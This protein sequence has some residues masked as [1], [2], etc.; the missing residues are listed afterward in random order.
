MALR[1]YHVNPFL[2]R[3]SARVTERA[4][5]EARPAV[6]RYQTAFSPT[7]GGKPFDRGALN[8]I[9]VVNVFERDDGEILHALA[10]P[11][12]FGVGDSVDGEIDWP[13]RFDHMQQHTGQHVLSAAFA[14]VAG[15]DT[16]SIHIGDEECTI[17]LPTPRLDPAL[18]ERVEDAANQTI[19]DDLPVVA[20]EVTAAELT[21][22]P[23]RKPPTVTGLIR[24]V[25]VQGL[26]WSACG[27]THVASTGQIGM[28]RV[29][30]AE[31]HGNE[32]RV[33]FHCGRRALRDY[34]QVSAVVAELTDGFRVSRQELPQ[35]VER[36]R[37]EA[38]A[39]RRALL[40]AQE[41]LAEADALAV[42]RDARDAGSDARYTIIARVFTDRDA[43]Q[44]KAIAKRL[45]AEPGIVALLGTAGEKASLC[46]ARSKDAAGDMGKLLRDAL[47][48]LGA[49]GGGSAD[50]A[51]G[52][53][54]PA[55]PN[56]IQH[57]L[58]RA[59]ITIQDALLTQS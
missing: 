54:V 46:F 23:L 20:R 14:R 33:Y 25:E 30:K 51:Q 7:S 57:A 21:S 19:Y 41:R 24:V 38:Q 34:R 22:I 13:R 15:L 35:A 16:L 27:G 42:L 9:D 39:A 32:T 18:I 2:R 58:D 36:L 29:C 1:L 5:I 17:D 44:L 8:G 50:F 47:T 6:A 45:T 3:F 49:K 31:K 37:A 48:A 53:G 59:R 43:T 12:K 55:N 28:I 10:R 52:G 26:D 4:S 56:Q 11:A 40:D